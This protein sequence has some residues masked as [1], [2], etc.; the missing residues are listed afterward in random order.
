MLSGVAESSSYLKRPCCLEQRACAPVI[1]TRSRGCSARPYR[2]RWSYSNYGNELSF[3]PFL[4]ST[5]TLL[6]SLLSLWG[7]SH[8]CCGVLPYPAPFFSIPEL[9]IYATGHYILLQY[10]R[11]LYHTFSCLPS[12]LIYFPL[13][14]SISVLYRRVRPSTPNHTVNPSPPPHSKHPTTVSSTWY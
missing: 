5:L 11:I 14:I 6:S 9:H 10:T 8:H 12:N 7:N 13:S 4:Y 3:T 1:G 2:A